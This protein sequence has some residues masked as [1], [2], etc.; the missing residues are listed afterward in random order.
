MKVSQAVIQ[1]KWNGK[2]DHAHIHTK[3]KKLQVGSINIINKTLVYQT[4][5][6]FYCFFF[7]KLAS[8]DLYVLQ[9][10]MDLCD[11]QAFMQ[12]NFFDLGNLLSPAYILTSTRRFSVLHLGKREN[13]LHKGPC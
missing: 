12:R 13:Q 4:S 1:S 2:E 7:F 9:A 6:L 10:F 11:L 3:L 8:S 5:T